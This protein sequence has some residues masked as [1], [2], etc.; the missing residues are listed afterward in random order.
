MRPNQA[1]IDCGGSASEPESARGVADL[2]VRQSELVAYGLGK[3]MSVERQE[4]RSLRAALNCHVGTGFHD[5]DL[6]AINVHS[7][8]SID[9]HG[10]ANLCVG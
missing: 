9:L 4:P 8:G 1:I 6:T 7:R 10:H 5:G 2:R 3:W